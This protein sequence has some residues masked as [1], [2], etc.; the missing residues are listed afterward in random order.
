MTKTEYCLMHPPIATYADTAFSGI[1]I[2]GVEY[3][4]CESYLYISRTC[5]KST[6]Y[7]RVKVRD[8]VYGSTFR[9][10]GRTYSTADVMKIY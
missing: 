2:H 3:D 8:G 7:H 6:T 9:V 5:G 1:A 4:A 10:C